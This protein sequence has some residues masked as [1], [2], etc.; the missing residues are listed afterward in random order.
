MI[1]MAIDKDDFQQAIKAI[2]RL[3]PEKKRQLIDQLTA[4][5]ETGD[6]VTPLALSGT[7]S[8][9]SLSAEDIAEGRRDCWAGLGR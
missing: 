6:R 1:V 3:S 7:W 9:V 8:G 4:D 5:L 2:Q